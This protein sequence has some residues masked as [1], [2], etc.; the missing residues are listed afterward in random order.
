M[1]SASLATEDILIVGA[2]PAGATASLFLAQAGI[3]HTLVDKAVF[4][5][6]K[7]D[8]NVFGAKVIDVLNRLSSDYFPALMAQR[9]RVQGSTGCRVFTP[10]GKHFD[11]K[12]QAK[13]AK[14]EGISARVPFFTVNRCH[15][16]QFLL[17]QL[18]KRYVDIRLGSAIAAIYRQSDRW[19][20]T[21]AHADAVTELTPQ[22]II[23]ADGAASF[24][25][26]QL[27]SSRK[28]SRR[29]SGKHSGPSCYDSVQ[30]Y[31]RNVE[32]CVTVASTTGSSASGAGIE[33]H[34]LP[35]VNPAFFF[36]TPLA[37]N[38]FSVGAVR[39]RREADATENLTQI[40]T[41]A[42]AHHPNLAP[43]FARSER[44]QELRPWPIAI[45][46]TWNRSV[47]GPGYLLTGDAAGLCNPLTC[48]GTGN[49]MISGQLAAEAVQRAIASPDLFTADL[50][51]YDRALYRQLQ[52]EFQ[53]GS[54]LNTLIG[55]DWLFNQLTSSHPIQTMARRVLRRP[56]AK[57]RQM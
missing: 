20:V 54:L 37:G 45:G 27:E 48:F 30:G 19:R 21:L 47:S 57:L 34:F 41:N 24:T 2:G 36:I 18:D 15:F 29:L 22:L 55:Q 23:A 52:S 3:P 31:F 53:I 6:D 49:A 8:G 16:D 33:G 38:L 13:A 46:S 10:N 42:I 50:G 28:G 56:L 4:P 40:V 39:A 9:D 17:D 32:G 14:Q 12:F 26:Q 44:V 7:V 51:T 43:R 35:E 5:R 11:L 25:A 1:A